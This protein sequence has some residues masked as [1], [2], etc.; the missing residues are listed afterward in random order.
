MHFDA[1]CMF[2]IKLHETVKDF[3]IKIFPSG[4]LEHLQKNWVCWKRVQDEKARCISNA[5]SKTN[6]EKLQDTV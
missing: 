5:Q 6:E 3:E 1:H 4:S 2:C